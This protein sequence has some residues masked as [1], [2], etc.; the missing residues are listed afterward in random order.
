MAKKNKTFSVKSAVSAVVSF[1]L[2]LTIVLLSLVVVLHTTLFN[3]RTIYSKVTDTT[4][5]AELNNDIVTRCQT[6]AAKNG[7]DYSFIENVIT[8]GRVDADYTVYFNSMS[9]KNPHGGCETID[10]KGLAE[11]IYK[12]ITVADSDMTAEEKENVRLASSE[13]AAEYKNTMVAETFEKFVGFSETFKS[14]SKYGFYIL[15]ALFVY[16]TGV[17]FWLNGKSQKHRLFRKFSIVGGSAGLTVLA[18]SVFMKVSG[19][20]NNMTFASTQREYNLFISFFDSFID[21]MIIVGAGWL[22]VCIVLLVLWYWSVTGR[23]RK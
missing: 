12:S 1:V 11:E 10:E 18:F 17:M 16:L 4:Y 6:I 15:S 5:F 13:I 20:L 7:I 14:Y 23:I 22:V 8:S 9:G 2:S 21:T 3:D 19:V